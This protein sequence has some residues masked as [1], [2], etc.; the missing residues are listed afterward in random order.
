[1][2]IVRHL[3]CLLLLVA[4]PALAQGPLEPSRLPPDTLFYLLWRGTASVETSRSTN[5][6]L[7]LWNDPQFTNARAAL[8]ASFSANVEKSQDAERVKREVLAQILSLAENPIILGLGGSSSVAG[9]AGSSRP[10]AFF[11][12]FDGTGKENI[13]RKLQQQSD[14]NAQPPPTITRYAVGPTTVEKVV[15]PKETYYRAQVG[16]YFLRANEQALMEDLIHRLRSPEKPATSLAESAEY[17]LAQR[18]LGGPSPLEFFGHLPDLAKIPPPAT[19]SFD[20][21]ALLRALHL[22][23][24]QA[25]AGNLSFAG[26]ASRMRMAALGDTSP[27]SVFD[28]AGESGPVFETLALAPRGT[29]YYNV[30]KVPFTGMYQLLRSALGEALPEKH[31]MMVDIVEAAAAQ[32]I[33]MS[34]P[35]ALGLLRGEVASIRPSAEFDTSSQLYAVAIQKQPEVLRLLR[36][37]LAKQITS[38]FSHRDASFLKISYPFGARSGSA[39]PTDLYLGVTPQMLLGAP[40]KELVEEAVARLEPKDAGAASLT[41]DAGFRQARARFPQN[42]TS[43]D[44]L[45]FT[46]MPWE[47]LS[48]TIREGI[49][50]SGQQSPS[51]AATTDAWLQAI[52]PAL[53]RRYLHSLSTGWWKAR[54]GIY[55][56]AYLD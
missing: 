43:L 4:A 26:A 19:E 44:Y 8:I 10:A 48:E 25:I 6:L 5:S 3:V 7:Q 47:K 46:R 13:L 33:G 50:K 39:D 34:L 52:S 41:A 35:D 45:D 14:A 24:L 28:L 56:D 37:I 31:R 23:R 15:R 11:A 21:G 27:G 49:R 32:Q 30:V 55:F 36:T 29:A 9:D 1:M 51:E 53:I 12:I 17:R 42:L 18:W 54:D 2:T 40:R 38:E 22:E 20:V 16:R